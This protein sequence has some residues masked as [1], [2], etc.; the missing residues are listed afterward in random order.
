MHFSHSGRVA[1]E[2]RVPEML[3][4]RAA[5]PA[6]RRRAELAARGRRHALHP[7]PDASQAGMLAGEDRA[8]LL[9][10]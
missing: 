8:H 10:L 7:P 1:G 9:V 4:D 6:E 3:E 2:P 5:R